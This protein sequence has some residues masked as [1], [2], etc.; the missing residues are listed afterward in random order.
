MGREK[1]WKR[2]DEAARLEDAA[3]F[4]LTCVPRTVLSG[5]SLA[6]ALVYKERTD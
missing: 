3:D 6:R 5:C 1:F 2:D 4:R